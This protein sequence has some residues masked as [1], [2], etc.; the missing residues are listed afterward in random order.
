MR[1]GGAGALY[2]YARLDLAPV[3]YSIST[4]GSVLKPVLV[5]N[6]D[7]YSGVMSPRPLSA[8]VE[9]LPGF[10]NA[11]DKRRKCRKCRQLA[12]LPDDA[13]HVILS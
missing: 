2:F 4:N 13:N 1:A 8:F 12:P 7:D 10:V 11:V 5:L 3:K 6:R 9:V